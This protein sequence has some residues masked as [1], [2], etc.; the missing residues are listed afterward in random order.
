LAD[1]GAFL[2]LARSDRN[3]RANAA[4]GEADMGMKQ[5][6]DD[7]EMAFGLGDEEIQATAKRQFVASLAVAVVIAAAAGLTALGPVRHD[8]ADAMQHKFALVRQPAFITSPAQQVA[9]ARRFEVEL[10]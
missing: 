4:I 2:R 8:S 7:E 10:P 6:V 1:F 5:L 9:S 3:Y